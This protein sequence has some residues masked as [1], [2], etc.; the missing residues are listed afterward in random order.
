MKTYF[1]AED[2]RITAHN[3][4]DQLANLISNPSD[5]VIPYQK[6]E[7]ALAF[8]KDFQ[9]NSIED[10][11]Q[12]VIDKSTKL[13]H[14]QY[15]GHQVVPPVPLSTLAGFVSEFLNNGMAVYEMGMA[16]NPMER[17]VCE[18]MNQKIGYDTKSNGI[19]TSGGTLG[20]LTALL[21]ARA[22]LTEV[23]S[24]GHSDKL[25]IMVSEE[26]HYCVDR[27]ARIMGLGNEGVIKIPVNDKYKMRTDLLESELDKAREKGLKVFAIIGSAGSTSTG[28]YE[29]LESMAT[30][31]AKHNV[32][33]HVDAAHGG[34]GLFSEKYKHLLNGIHLADSVVID[35]HK[36]MMVPALATAVLYKNGQDSYNTFHQ[37]A[38]YLW[39]SEEEDWYNSGKRTFECT[40][41]GMCFKVYAIW[42]IYGENIFTQNVEKL[43]EN[44]E[45]FA[46][47]VEEHPHFELA[48][49]PESNIVNFR[50]IHSDK[51][52]N[53]LNS[54]L[55]QKLIENGNFYIVQTVLKGKVFLRVSLMNPLTNEEHLYKLLEELSEIAAQL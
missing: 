28:A 14:P 29:D 18:W 8:W 12:T 48:I 42:K 34:A 20:N 2:F 39:A 21:T 35:F 40:K 54:G 53:E 23:W 5:K 27:A 43:H 17:L 46:S 15:M 4:V 41:L 52:L 6:P 32:W 1:N 45:V 24:E 11:F 47:L 3:A 10:L 44:A 51:N 30:F 33:F 19:I 36:M 49:K 38:Q 37:K 16:F 55:R 50:Y 25:A 13:H 22:K 26:A 9:P 31:A 7:D